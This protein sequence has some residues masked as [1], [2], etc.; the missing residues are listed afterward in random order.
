VATATEVPFFSPSPTSGW[1]RT[2]SC[3]RVW[4]RCCRVRKSPVPIHS[5]EVFRTPPTKDRVWSGHR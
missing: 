2:L 4:S 1:G 5:S 3:P